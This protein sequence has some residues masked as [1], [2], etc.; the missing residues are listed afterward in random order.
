MK[1]ITRPAGNWLPSARDY[2]LLFGLFFT[3]STPVFADDPNWWHYQSNWH[4]T[5]EDPNGGIPA[6]TFTTDWHDGNCWNSQN[7]GFGFGARPPDDT[8]YA[9]IEAK[10]P[11]LEIV[12]D[13]ECS[14]LSIHPWSW[15]YAP[16]IEVNI[17][18]TAGTISCGVCI[19]IGDR[20]DY[21][22]ATQG[23]GTLNVYGGTMTTPTAPEGPEGDIS[24][25]WVG[26]G[27]Y[28][29]GKCYGIV[30]MYGG[31]IT[32]PRIAVYY[33]VVNLYGGLLY[34]TGTNTADLVIFKSHA[35]NKINVCDDGDDQTPSG[36][37]RLQGDRVQQVYYYIQERLIC[38]C[39]EQKVLAVGYQIP[40]EADYTLVKQVRPIYVDRSAAGANNGS[41]W[42]D[43]FNH[44]Q[45]ALFAAEPPYV[46]YVAQ[47]TYRPDEDTDNPSGTGSRSATFQL[48]NGVA[49]FGGFPSGGGSWSSRNPSTYQTILSG[50]LDVNVNSYHVVTGSGANSSAVLDGF[51]I[52][53][54]RAISP[55][56][57]EGGGL[58]NNSGSPTINNCTFSDNW[59]YDG[60]AI[61][62]FNNSNPTI[63]NCTFTGGN[64]AD[65]GGA[66]YNESGNPV[67]TGCTF[68]GSALWG[69]GSAMFTE[70]GYSPRVN[71]CT[72]GG[73]LTIQGPGDINIVY[74]GEMV[75]ESNAVVDLNDP[76]DPNIKGTIQCDGLLKVKDNGQLKHATVNVS[77]QTGGYFGK[78]EVEDSAQATNLDIHTDGD[79]FMDVDPCT[80]TG[81]IA[82][83]RI[84]VT[85]TEGQSGSTEGILE[86]R[87]RELPSHLCDFNDPNVRVCQ[88][89]DDNMP[90]FDT[91][92]WTLERLEIA[93]GAKVT[94]MDRFSSGND[95]PEVSY[96]K[97]LVL[98]AG[99]VLN[100]GLEHL[101]YMDVNGDSNSIKR[102]SQLGFSLD[103][104]D[105]D[106]NEEFQ[107]R[108]GNNNYIDPVDPN[109]NRIQVERVT[110]LDPDP[111][112]F[113]K[114]SNFEDEDGNVIYARA[115]AR[116][117]P[118]SEDKIRIQFNYLF[119]TSDP[120]SQ[121]VVYLSDVPEMLLIDPCDP[122]FA[123]HYKYV[124]CIL[125]PPFPRPGSAG[126]SRFGDFDMYVEKG[127]LDLSQ[128]TWVELVLIEPATGGGYGKSM[129]SM[130][131]EEGHAS[132]SIDN[133]GSS[134]PCFTCWGKCRDLV[135]FDCI[136]NEA[137]FL[138]VVTGTGT[139]DSPTCVDGVFSGDGYT[140]PYDTPSWDWMLKDEE[141]TYLCEQVPLSGGESF[142]TGAGQLLNLSGLNDL[143]ISGK[144]GDNDDAIKM[145]DRLYV[146]D[147]SYVCKQYIGLEPNDRCNIR[148]VRG[149][150]SDLYQI[151]SE[152]G[153]LR[154]DTGEP[155]VPPGQIS[156]DIN[157]PRYKQPAVVYAGIG[158]TDSVPYGRPILDAAFD[159]NEN[160]VYVVP[161]V[162][163]PNGNVPYAAA[164]K[165]QLN[166]LPRCVVKLYDGN[167]LPNDN[168]REYR[169]SLREIELD[170]A[171]N[172]YVTNA[173]KMNA[174]DILWKFDPNGTVV[175]RLELDPCDPCSPRV[176][177]PVGMCV[178]SATNMLYI[179]SA[180]HCQTDPNLTVIRGFSTATLA[181]ART[182][183][184]FG[185]HHVTGI[186]EDPNKALWVTGFNLNSNPAPSPF[187]DPYLA[188]VP[189]DI[190]DV[191][192]L[193]ISGDYD[194]AMPLS[195]C[196]T[197]ALQA[198]PELCG[199]ADLNGNGTVNMKDLAILARHWLNSNCGAP[200]NPCEGADLEPEA[201]PDGDVDIQDL[202]I[203]AHNWL[204]INCQ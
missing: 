127:D 195:I 138:K 132:G 204:N 31:Q 29:T 30:N 166:P 130:D 37:L 43:A 8:V 154:L 157:E 194:L 61:Y 163:V 113:M 20:T 176:R 76:C 5:Y 202:D 161:V 100:V 104:V 33:G 70:S 196:W 62:D 107:S 116:F 74:G 169:N 81:T 13:V 148:I 79:R 144:R 193:Y 203:L 69:D 131:S 112:G 150:G 54:G 90:A 68:T 156:C 51:T 159:A 172:V 110:G 34:H 133:W 92:S 93:A 52:T 7:N 123:A 186:T 187:Y 121:I 46:I 124:G 24:G 44:I 177:A 106:S 16:N 40:P 56:N 58:Y 57:A 125:N 158:G 181:P 118:A 14:R 139:I 151:N 1:S 114:M 108:V 145:K 11:G 162:V 12:G 198:P 142:A 94:L 27:Q 137:D 39:E 140:D 96:V 72:F 135:W 197:G 179:A 192:A 168:Q 75:I 149:Q 50:N 82:N 2:A 19:G 152:K 47:G 21:D 80:F 200:N 115:K 160:F 55:P 173:N 134:V 190:N 25:L 167:L 38:P 35:M 178:S 49:L 64:S 66:I 103:V 59:A 42:G 36:E 171:G 102:D 175:W 78:F 89:D 146:F 85:I 143:L 77:R 164:A 122:D 87:G 182:I 120:C 101:Y 188:K 6:T 97:D 88:I 71:N 28:K 17:M 105:C 174:S 153:V 67:L 83:N 9:A 53:Q 45:D 199:G 165:I 86:V 119:N 18:P 147:S 98:G 23:H 189:L 41:S 109:L 73:T 185:M 111:N 117:A 191:N 126:S 95:D 10:P 128:G 15:E 141:R 63:T 26:G 84:Y 65:R 170:S 32:V 180:L 136:V 201:I 60:G 91:N 3:I 129:H 4:S 22:S 48:N 183:T 184:V 99:C 155:I